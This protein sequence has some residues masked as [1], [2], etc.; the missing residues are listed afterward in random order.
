M[1]LL[2]PELLQILACPKCKAPLRET[3][4]QL[5]CSRPDC[6]LRFRI[7]NGVPILLIDKA[8]LPSS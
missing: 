6:G 3:N 1:T 4:D 7:E 8:E 2:K 5:A